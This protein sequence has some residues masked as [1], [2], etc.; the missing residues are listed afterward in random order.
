MGIRV[1]EIFRAVSKRT[2]Q[3]FDYIPGR[4]L[5]EELP[6]ATFREEELTP[7]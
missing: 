6:L 7:R 3:V 4:D 2:Q 5:D 1:A